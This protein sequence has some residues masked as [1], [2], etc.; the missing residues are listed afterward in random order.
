MRIYEIR[1]FF[2]QKRWNPNFFPKRQRFW[3][4]QRF[5][6]VG[7]QRIHKDFMWESFE[8]DEHET[9]WNRMKFT[10][11]HR[12][13]ACLRIS[14]SESCLEARSKT[15]KP[16]FLRFWVD[17]RELGLGF[18]RNP[19]GGEKRKKKK[20]ENER[21]RV[22]CPFI[23]A[24]G[25]VDPKPGLLPLFSGRLIQIL[26]DLDQSNAPGASAWSGSIRS[27]G[28]GHR[29]IGFRV[30]FVVSWNCL[31]TAPAFLLFEP[32]CMPNFLQKIPKFYYVFLIC[33]W[34]IS[35]IFTCSEL[36]EII[37]VNFVLDSYILCGFAWIFLCNFWS[38]A[39]HGMLM[40]GV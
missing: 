14:T 11:P 40:L 29:F 13:V 7:N 36:M 18:P 12:L 34:L 4:L 20:E 25:R 21:I 38:E 33:F 23:Y 22:F 9:V 27:V 30:F 37:C 8:S 5:L 1:S 31:L 28:L 2:I 16:R 17:S 26:M 32:I 24:L 19:N 35:D 10:N 39:C 3:D 6:T 15:I